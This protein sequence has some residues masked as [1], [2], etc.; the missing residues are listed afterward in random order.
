MNLQTDKCQI[1]KEGTAEGYLS[2][3]VTRD[4]KKT[5]LSQPGLTKRIVEAL[6][7]SSK[8]STLV[9]TPAEKA[10][11]ARDLD[12]APA[13]ETFSYPSVIGMLHY[14]GHTRPDCAFIVRY[15][16]RYYLR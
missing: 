8:Y 11:L 2:L 16:R 7:L 4:G 13:T 10:P 9:S 12:G 15:L 3:Q 6:G 5:T 14:L 1:R